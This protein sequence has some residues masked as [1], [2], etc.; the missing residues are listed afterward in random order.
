VPD[1]ADLQLI[2]GYFRAVESN[3]ER[4]NLSRSG[5]RVSAFGKFFDH[6]SIEYWMSS[7]LRLETSPLSTTTS[8]STTLRLR[9]ACRSELLATKSSFCREQDPR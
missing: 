3:L 2:R 1:K 7:G 4:G 8:S 5:C 6:L 9:C